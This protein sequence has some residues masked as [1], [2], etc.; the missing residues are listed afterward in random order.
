MCRSTIS[1][2][3][4]RC[5]PC[6]CWFCL[7]TNKCHMQAVAPWP[8]GPMAPWPHGPMAPWPHGPMPFKRSL[9][10]LSYCLIFTT[11]TYL[12][13]ATLTVII[14]LSAHRLFGNRLAVTGWKVLCDFSSLSVSKTE[15]TNMSS[16]KRELNFIGQQTWPS[17]AS[18]PDRSQSLWPI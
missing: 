7:H 1:G 4:R 12:R 16:A 17:S 15:F 11:Q 14:V 6:F 10:T 2:C 18:K 13:K 5:L 3:Q 8:H 9:L